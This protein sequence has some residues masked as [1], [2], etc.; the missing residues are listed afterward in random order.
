MPRIQAAYYGD[1]GAVMVAV[2]SGGDVNEE[3][4]RDGSRPIHGAGYKHHPA[5]AGLWRAPRPP[6]MSTPPLVAW[7]WAIP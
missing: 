5:Q 4:P 3:D 6:L 1:L 7:Y 2:R